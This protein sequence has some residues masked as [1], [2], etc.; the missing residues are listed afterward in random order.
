[1]TR[2]ER[3]PWLDRDHGPAFRGGPVPRR[4]DQEPPPDRP[5]GEMGAP[6]VRPVLIGERDDAQ[7]SGGVETQ[8]PPPP[9]GT[10]RAPLQRPPEKPPPGKSAGAPAPAPPPP[11]PPPP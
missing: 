10:P 3:A 11:P 4:G 8:L 9:P 1:M 6:G 2:P 5:R 7:P